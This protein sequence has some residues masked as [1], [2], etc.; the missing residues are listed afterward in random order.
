MNRSA[1]CGDHIC[2]LKIYDGHVA[3]DLKGHF[4]TVFLLGITACGGKKCNVLAAL[5][6]RSLENNALE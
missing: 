1:V 4:T 2:G 5:E 6:F 3:G